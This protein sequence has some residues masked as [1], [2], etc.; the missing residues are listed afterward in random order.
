MSGCSGQRDVTK[1]LN[2]Q[3][4]DEQALISDYRFL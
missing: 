1:F 4:F 3:E 2:K